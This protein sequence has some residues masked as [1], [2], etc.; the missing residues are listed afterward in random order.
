MMIGKIY[1][2]GRLSGRVQYDVSRDTS[3]KLQT[4]LTSEKGYS[5]VCFACCSRLHLSL[6]HPLFMPLDPAPAVIRPSE[7]RSRD[8]GAL[9]ESGPSLSRPPL[10]GTAG[11][12]ARAR[13]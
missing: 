8:E 2:D 9:A 11:P 1:T 5:Q 7:L 10:N 3:L 4:Q 6:L 13:R 12:G